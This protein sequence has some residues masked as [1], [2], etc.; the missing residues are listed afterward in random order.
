[1]TF[2]RPLSFGAPSLFKTRQYVW[3]DVVLCNLVLSTRWA[4]VNLTFT[5]TKWPILYWRHFQTHFLKKASVFLFKFHRSLFL[6][7]QLLC[8]SQHSDK[9]VSP[10]RRHAITRTNLDV[11]S[12]MA[13]LS[14]KELKRLVDESIAIKFRFE[15]SFTWLFNRQL[16][17]K[18]IFDFCG[19]PS[20]DLLSTWPYRFTVK[21]G[22][23]YF[24]NLFN[25]VKW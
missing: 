25:P 21:L 11:R 7:V 13:S 22:K 3:D 14:H 1:M 24:P 5:F 6:G 18:S 20:V 19:E 4:I 15:N 16:V 9:R 8:I 2:Q 10:N 17:D 23:N 12:N